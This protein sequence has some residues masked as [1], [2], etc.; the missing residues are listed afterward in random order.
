MEKYI[1]TANRIV[2]EVKRVVIG[3]DEVIIKVLTSILAGGHILLE[4]IP[5]VGKT[6][7]ALAFAKSMSLDYNR[8]QFTP[9]V[10]PSDVTGFT[11]YNSSKGEFEYK[12]GAVLCNLFLADEIN[13][14][15]SKTQSSLLEV[16]EEGKVTVDAVSREV[17]K[18]FVVIATENPVGSVGT[19]K[20]P[21]SQLDRFM[22]CLSMGYPSV[23]SEVNILKNKQKGIDVSDVKA[24]ASKEEVIEMIDFISTIY[25]A[26]EIFEYIANLAKASREH[27]MLELGLSP[28]GTIALAALAKA[29]AFMHGR[30][31][32][33]PNDIK[34]IYYCATDHRIIVNQ[35]GRIAKKSAHDINIEVLLSVPVPEIK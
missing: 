6:T 16:M 24:V 21:E 15:S 13:R 26:D 8:L 17:K 10:L 32:V 30:N 27:N 20:L 1:E 4:D 11:I 19:Q 25:I 34:E 29:N 18:P 9:D 35:A 23:E 33:I 22:V 3:K 14:T 28:R 12:P 5:G 2:S 7:M 31:Y